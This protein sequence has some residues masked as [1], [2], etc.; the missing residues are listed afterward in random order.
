[1]ISL[2]TL[3]DMLDRKIPAEMEWLEPWQPLEDSGD[4]LVAELQKELAPGHP[5]HGV[6]VVPLARRIDCDDV[7]FATA[8]PLHALA[9]VHLTWAGKTERDPRWPWTTLFSGW[10]DWRER[11]L[12]PDHREYVSEG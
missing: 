9:V 2:D 10:A 11:F 12:L 1:M 6:D 5:L 4:P 7:L 8:N 3:S